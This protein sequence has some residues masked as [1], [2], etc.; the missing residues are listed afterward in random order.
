MI[1]TSTLG[2]NVNAT[3]KLQCIVIY[4]F[5]LIVL[6]ISK[7]RYCSSTFRKLKDAISTN[8]AKAMAYNCHT[9]IGYIYIAEGKVLSAS[10]VLVEGGERA[11]AEGGILRTVVFVQGLVSHRGN[12]VHA[13]EIA[14]LV[15]AGGEVR[16]R[17]VVAGIRAR[18]V[19]VR[20]G[21][22]GEAEVPRAGGLL[23]GVELEA[24]VPRAGGARAGAGGEAVGPRAGGVRAGVA[25]KRVVPQRCR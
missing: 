7:P 21:A 16:A 1:V 23:A 3:F 24:G 18:G 15:A 9:L 10:R 25:V 8:S 12:V 17:V 19:A 20:A 11:R 13:V 4:D 5:D 22:G 6:T 14:A 2:C